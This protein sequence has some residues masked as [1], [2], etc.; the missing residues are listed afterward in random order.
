VWTRRVDSPA[1]PPVIKQTDGSSAIALV[2]SLNPLAPIRVAMMGLS[3][4]V[5]HIAAL[6]VLQQLAERLRDQA[7]S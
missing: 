3:V 6:R 1:Q 4:C 7:F 2:S 5:L